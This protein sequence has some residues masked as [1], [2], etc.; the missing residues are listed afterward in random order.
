M[1]KTFA[2]KVYQVVHDI[3]REKVL[4]YKEVAQ[5]AGSPRA[6]RAVGNLMNKNYDNTVPCHRVIRSDGKIGGFREG[7]T[8]KVALL[9]KEGAI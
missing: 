9:K 8:K 5:H 6:Y 2:Q 7:T 3:P 1:H 4:T